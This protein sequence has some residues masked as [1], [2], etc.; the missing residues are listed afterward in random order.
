MALDTN[1]D[2]GSETG[3]TLKLPAGS[4][5]PSVVIKFSRRT[6]MFGALAAGAAPAV[7]AVVFGYEFGRLFERLFNPKPAD[8][9]IALTASV[10]NDTPAGKPILFPAKVDYQGDS[11]SFISTY[12]A[13]NKSSKP[14]TGS[15][16]MGIYPE[17]AI[18]NPDKTGQ[19]V[20]IVKG[21]DEYN[22]YRV[23]MA[24]Q[25]QAV[26]SQFNNAEYVYVIINKADSNYKLV[27]PEGPNKVAK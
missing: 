22:Y 5:N 3:A 15:N 17:D 8:K 11:S 2:N 4:E 26:R 20:V 12:E 1:I 10:I 24:T 14:Y 21:E 18:T 25:P 19:Q 16:K 13:P 23:S 9:K 6:L 27:N 7:E